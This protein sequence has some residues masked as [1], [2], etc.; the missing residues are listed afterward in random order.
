MPV[1]N[2]TRP[3]GLSKSRVLAARQCPR[4]LWLETHRPALAEASD[5]QRLR[6]EG[7][8]RLGE[9]ARALLGGGHLVEHVDDLAAALDATRSLI[10]GARPGERLFEAAFS[11][12]AC[13]SGSTR[14]SW[15]SADGR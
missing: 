2:A 12:G 7:G 1:R 15:A 4:R 11:Q 14:W 13:W 3:P 9:L 5:D 8:T 6:V 10:D